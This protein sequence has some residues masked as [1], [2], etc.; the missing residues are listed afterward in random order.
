MLET[1]ARDL[2]VI[3]GGPAGVCGAIAAAREG[4][5]VALV[6][7]RPVLGGNS[8]SEIRMWTRGATGGGNLF[9]EEMGILGELKLENLY[10]NP[11]GNIHLWDELLLDF[12]LREAGIA[13]FLNTNVMELEMAGKSRIAAVRGRQLGSEREFG[14]VS[15]IFL[16]ATGDATVGFLAGAAYR[17]GREGKAEFGEEFAPEEPDEHTLG[18]TILLQT[19]ETKRK[20][21]FVPPSYAY[22]RDQVRGLLNRGGRI[23]NEKMNGCDFWWLEYGGMM[24]TIRDNQEIG[25]ELKRI[26]L[27]LWDYIKN[28]GIYDADRLTLDWIGNLPGKRESRRLIGDY[29]LTQNDLA[30]HREFEDAVCYGGWF[31]D[32]HPPEGIYS[33][34]DHCRQIPVS[35]YD[36]PM[37]CL[38][39]KNIEN[40]LMAGRNIS[41]SHAAFAST[42]IMNTCALTGQAA[43]TIAGFAVRLDKSPRK[44]YQEDRE[45]I[46]QRL[47][48]NDMY[49]I[50]CRNSD[51][52]DRAKTARITASSVRN[53]GN[54]SP[55]EEYPL[56]DDLFVLFPWRAGCG[57]IQLRL[58]A[59]AATVLEAELYRCDH[60]AGFRRGAK[61]AACAVRVDAAAESWVELPFDPEETGSYHLVVK[62]NPKV[63]VYAA[64]ESC[65]GFLAGWIAGGSTFSPCC[66]LAGLD[67]LYGP[68]NLTNGYHRPYRL[69][70]LWISDRM[71]AGHPETVTFAWEE[72]TMIKEIRLFFNPDLAKELTNYRG[73]GWAEHHGY[74]P[75]TGMPPELVRDYRISALQ[76]GEWRPLLA[77]KDNRKRLAVHGFAPVRAEALRLE[78]E[79]TYGSPYIELFE[80][81]VY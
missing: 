27:G 42:R 41:V 26:A 48:A 16:D 52:N 40:L 37:R 79:S 71:R 19:R 35:V 49:L 17:R 74:M 24:D 81:R 44:L 69:P 15:P 14:F 78:F 45:A 2:T 12:V 67:L 4:L 33:A 57:R 7:N 66:R 53:A 51:R 22:T 13:L 32:F 18:S 72:A 76:S 73:E 29:I 61:L 50:G 46:R 6:H 10:R 1:I 34:E 75:R 77:V 63:A 65:T 55:A 20:V 43:G 54:E 28:S 56:K 64:Q 70:N 68:N 59:A 80:V 38:Y 39:S 23:V 47:L 62:G 25:L 5:S 30:G 8:S 36:I 9:A 31:L 21:T 60:P 58:A 3:G 11:E